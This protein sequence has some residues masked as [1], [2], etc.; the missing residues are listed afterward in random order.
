MNGSVLV[1]RVFDSQVIS[2]KIYENVN[3]QR[4]F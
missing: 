2:Y 1:Q 3:T 4:Q